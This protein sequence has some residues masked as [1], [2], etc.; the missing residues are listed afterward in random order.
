MTQEFSSRSHR[1]EA[2]SAPRTASPPEELDVCFTP[3][4]KGSADF[5]SMKLVLRDTD[6]AVIAPSFK[7]LFWGV[8]ILV[9]GLAIMFGSVRIQPRPGES[10]MGIMAFVGGIG[11]L[12]AMA[13]AWILISV[14]FFTFDRR[15]GLCWSGRRRYSA[16]GKDRSI[17]LEN[18]LALQE[19]AFD[20]RY[21]RASCRTYELN[22]VLADPP[23][24]RVNVMSVGDSKKFLQDVDA[25]A[26]FLGKPIWGSPDK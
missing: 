25:L 24:K 6:T 16:A 13:G 11:L 15:S 14:R 4:T 17:R 18:I 2:R 21:P 5:Q 20:V 3:L 9:M 23:G 7:L 19:L 1:R 26:E 12:F 8:A 10:R 22:L